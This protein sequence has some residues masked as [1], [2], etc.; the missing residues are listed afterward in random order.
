MC[1]NVKEFSKSL[2]QSL[3]SFI[4]TMCCP[5]FWECLETT[6]HFMNLLDF[7]GCYVCCTVYL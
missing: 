7:A 4:L 2:T 1:T 5:G 6:A 3:F